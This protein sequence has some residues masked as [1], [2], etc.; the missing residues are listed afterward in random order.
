MS[1]DAAQIEAVVREQHALQPFSG[2]VQV[3]NRGGIVFTTALDFAHRA[4]AI[5]NVPSTRFG[6]ASGT[7]TFTALGVCQLIEAG[8]LS[9]DT[10][11][12]DV[13]DE[14]LPLFDPAITIH[15]LLTHTSG[16]PDYFDEEEL[17]AQADF[18]AVFADLPVYRVLAPSD[19]LPLFRDEP[20]KSVLG[21]RFHYN[22]GGFVLLGLVIE[23]VSG[24][25]Y[26]DYVEQHVLARAGMFDS[27]FFE[28]TDLPPRTAYGY[29][30]DG[31]TNIYEVPIRGMPDGGAFVTAPDM[32]AFWDALMGSQL[33]GAEMTAAFLQPRVEVGSG[34]DGAHYGYGLWMDVAEGAVTRYTCAGAD[35]GVAFVSSH[36]PSEQIELTVLGNSEADA[37]PLFAALK[38]LL[39]V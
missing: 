1:L 36:F 38:R 29:L 3:R 10:R 11:L 32:A 9:T 21:E 20:M 18:S 19:I 24:M 35:P 15:H 28:M 7:K 4:E 31:R 2:V 25:A 17:D 16:A 12:A 39:V 33:L 26:T 23:A 37:W 14:A 8:R 6:T 34:D 27:G 30:R 22:N 5:P 13:V